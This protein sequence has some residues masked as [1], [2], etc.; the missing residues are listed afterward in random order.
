M[1]RT[2]KQ[3]LTVLLAVAMIAGMLVMPGVAAGE[4]SGNAG[5]HYYNVELS[6]DAVN[7]YATGDDTTAT[8]TYTVAADVT[9][10]A[11]SVDTSVADVT[12]GEGEITISAVGEGST[13]VYV[14]AADAAVTT[15]AEAQAA[16]DKLVVIPV[17]VAGEEADTTA[18][19]A[20][21]A[22]AKKLADTYTVRP[23]TT[24]ADN[25]KKGS[26][27][28]LQSDKDALDAAI[29]AAQDVAD[30]AGVAQAEVDTALAALND[31]M[32]AF[33]GA[34]Q[35]G[36]KTG[37][38]TTTN[39]RDEN[40][41]ET[42]TPAIVANFTDV[43]AN[44]WFADSVKYCLDK[45]LVNGTSGTTFDPAKSTTRG[46]AV[47]VLARMAGVDTT[48]GEA[49]YTKGVD[50]AVEQGISDGTN[51]EGTITREQMV[52]MLYRYAKATAV[53]NATMDFVDADQISDWAVEGMTWA[54]SKG[55]I[56][57]RGAQDLDPQGVCSRAELVAMLTRFCK[58]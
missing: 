2:M 19:T 28:V 8:V 48:D 47:T 7:V 45:K 3:M 51:P 32:D 54:V 56:L 12:V 22:A 41:S 44:A 21:I 40:R 29:Q 27:Y 9:V 14:V 10:Y 55:I 35:T 20:A 5:I 38:N 18:L 50:W 24:V 49:W 17:T 13:Y 25:V 11:I 31:A 46:M 43:P 57:G 16:G 53:E 58:L 26:K 33:N 6:D 52:V 4:E 15:V 34:V 23:D 1:K 37:T 39:Y 42:T 30:K 36:A